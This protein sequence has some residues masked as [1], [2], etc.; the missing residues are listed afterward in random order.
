MIGGGV[1]ELLL[2][3]YRQSLKS[4]KKMGEAAPKEDQKVIASIVSDL[5]H[6]IKWMH[7]RQQPVPKKSRQVGFRDADTFERIGSVDFFNPFAP[8][9]YEMVEEKIDRERRLV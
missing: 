8:T 9:A 4:T 5:E 6:A 1:V 3:E 2:E 7:T